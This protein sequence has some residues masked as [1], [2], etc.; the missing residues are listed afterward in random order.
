MILFMVLPELAP[1]EERQG[2]ALL[3]QIM[4]VETPENVRIEYP[5][6]GMG[7]R[8]AAL[9]VDAAIILLAAI[10]V[11]L[12]G[13][14]LGANVFDGGLL[15]TLYLIYTFL[16]LWGYFFFFEGFRDG[17][18]PG[19]KMLSVRV[20]ME[21]GYPLSVEAA[22]IR[23]LIRFIDL[24][25]APSCLMGGLSMVL[26]KQSRRLGDLAAGTVVVRELPIEF[27]EVAEVTARA[28]KPQ[29]TDQAFNAL[30]TFVDRRHQVQPKA[31]KLLAIKLHRELPKTKEDESASFEERLVARYADETARRQTA[32]MSVKSG[33]AA[34]TALL[35]RKRSS[36]LRFRAR[37]ARARE[38]GLKRF[39]ETEVN[40]FAE[41]FREISA[42]LARSRT[43]GAS[44]GTL[45]ALE[46]VVGSGHNQFYRPARKS[47]RRFL[48]WLIAGFPTLVRKRW[49]PIA[50]SMALL[51]GPTILMFTLLVA[52]PELEEI[53]ANPAMIV[54]AE[55]ALEPDVDYRDTWGDVWVGSPLLSSM[56]IANNIQ[57]AFKAFA[58]GFL[59][60]IGSVLILIINGLSFGGALAVF[61]NR[62]VLDNIGA[63]V[64]P[65]GFIELTAICI[66]GGA[67][68][69]MGSAF[70]LPGRERR[71]VALAS[72]AKEAISMVAGVAIMLL[73]A[74]L[75]EGFISPA[76]ITPEIK[77]AAGALFA[78]ATIWYFAMAGRA[79]ERAS[80]LESRASRAA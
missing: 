20:V 44:A 4:G 17:Q 72:R 27:P 51:Y 21:G 9:L 14:L 13:A 22:G 6:A 56:L 62:G 8:F 66:A 23:N 31:A 28:E 52:R 7:S 41:H 2:D 58:S 67:G 50:L 3:H 57:V 71:F 76:R 75:I 49:K 18:T 54:R 12:A 63:F 29:L 61:A 78:A 15:L 74:G 10:F 53:Y 40:E 24:Q 26:T 19:K 39:S 33:S 45:F 68:I 30:E 11:P 70:I 25:P 46:R 59:A 64:L 47:I 37:V 35:R 38:R 1:V 69:W 5:L 34:A 36:W 43:Y 79:A 55:R 48:T 73:I 77:Y 80:E 32:R 42:D 65:H 60:C 16:L